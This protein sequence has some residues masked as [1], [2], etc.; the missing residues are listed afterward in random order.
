MVQIR[1]RGAGG[2]GRGKKG[3]VT[4]RSSVLCPAMPATLPSEPERDPARLSAGMFPRHTDLL[5]KAGKEK[6]YLE[7][8]RLRGDFTEELTSFHQPETNEKITQALHVFNITLSPI[9]TSFGL[10]ILLPSP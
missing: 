8:V 7:I 4:V 6:L 9:Q 2:G 10:C 5:Q 1:K 3:C